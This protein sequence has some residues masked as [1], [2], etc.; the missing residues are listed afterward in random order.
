MTSVDESG[1]KLG[2]KALKENPRPAYQSDMLGDAKYGTCY[3]AV[4]R[5]PFG[6]EESPSL[7][8]LWAKEKGHW[9]LLPGRLTFHRE[10]GPGSPRLTRRRGAGSNLQ[11]R[12]ETGNTD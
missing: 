1:G 2:L 12:S 7:L 11:S 9:K 10:P 5:L 4:S 8:L 3:L 6:Q